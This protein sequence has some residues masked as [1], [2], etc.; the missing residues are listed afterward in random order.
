MGA[1]RKA[2]AAGFA[3]I[4][5]VDMGGT[6]ADICLVQDGQAELAAQTT[7]GGLPVRTPLFDIVSVGAGCGSLVS[8]DEGGML[9]VGPRSAGADPGPACYGKGG[10]EPT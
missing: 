5:T 1:I 9:R 2:E 10:L 8:L 4:I 6:S 7:V 3:D